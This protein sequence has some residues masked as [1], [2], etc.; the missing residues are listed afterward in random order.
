MHYFNSFDSWKFFLSSS[1]VMHRHK[2]YA[3]SKTRSKKWES[4]SY[5]SEIPK[6]LNVIL[7]SGTSEILYNVL[8]GIKEAS[9]NSE[10]LLGQ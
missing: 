8:L 1:F 6:I 4:A 3:N 5:S 7:T 10:I 9:E 2:L